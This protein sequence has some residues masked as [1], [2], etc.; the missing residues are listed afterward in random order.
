MSKDLRYLLFCLLP[1]S[2]S[3]FPLIV[4]REEHED[5]ASSEASDSPDPKP[6]AGST[7]G[8]LTKARKAEL[9]AKVQREMAGAA[10]KTK[11]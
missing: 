11:S 3:L 4:C 7:T 8:K 10:K 6:A 2:H 5:D 1:R 9:T